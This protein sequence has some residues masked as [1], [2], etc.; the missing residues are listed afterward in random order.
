MISSL[1]G[2]IMCISIQEISTVYRNTSV[3]N[4]PLL[5]SMKSRKKL[6][7]QPH[8]LPFKKANWLHPR[9]SLRLLVLSCNS[10]L[11]QHQSTW[12]TSHFILS[13][14][15]TKRRFRIASNSTVLF[16]QTTDSI[17]TRWHSHVTVSFSS[18]SSVFSWTQTIW[19]AS[20]LSK[21]SKLYRF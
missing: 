2:C 20:L 21:S 13:Q 8:T 11:V 19:S 12:I 5:F 10:K 1:L 3:L 7:F 14:L 18:S 4:R 15:N 6:A 17:P 16:S 9:R